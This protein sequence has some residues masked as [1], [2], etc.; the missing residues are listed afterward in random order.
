WTASTAARPKEAPGG[1]WS[2]RPPRRCASR[3]RFG[4]SCH[5]SH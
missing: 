3:W 4:P 1:R 5:E 2:V